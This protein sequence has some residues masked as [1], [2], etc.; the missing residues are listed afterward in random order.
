MFEPPR[1]PFGAYLC[2]LWRA[3]LFRLRRYLPEPGSVRAVQ[4]LCR[5]SDEMGLGKT[6]QAIAPAEH[7]GVAGPARLAGPQSAARHLLQT[8]DCFRLLGHAI[9]LSAVAVLTLLLDQRERSHVR[10]FV[11]QF[12]QVACDVP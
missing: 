5:I 12:V 4:E 11:R 3:V 9:R 1:V 6:V 10:D 8:G 7:E 2:R